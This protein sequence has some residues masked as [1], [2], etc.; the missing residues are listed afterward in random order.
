MKYSIICENSVGA[1]EV[2]GTDN[3]QEA[4]FLAEQLETLSGGA[5]EFYYVHENASNYLF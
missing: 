5:A 2:T 4:V 1:N 3:H